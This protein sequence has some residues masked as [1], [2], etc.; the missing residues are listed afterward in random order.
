MVLL[1]HF[2]GTNGQTTFTDNSPVANTLTATAVTVATAQQKFGTGSGIFSGGG[3]SQIS[4]GASTPF[5]FGTGHFT[6]EVWGYATSAPSPGVFSLIGNFAASTGLGWEFYFNAGFLTFSWSPNGTT[7]ITTENVSYAPTLNTWVA[8]AVDYDGSNVRLY[9]N[10]A[11]LSAP[12]VNPSIFTGTQNN[13]II[14]NDEVASREWPGYL[15]EIRVTSG[16]ARYAGAY[17]PATA[18]FPNS[19]NSAG[20]SRE[21]LLDF[22]RLCFPS[23]M[24]VGALAPLALGNALKRN[25][26]ST[27][28]GLLR[29]P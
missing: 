25:K 24:L 8:Y 4:T 9:A 12:G 10:G 7:P 19:A 27:R 5:K 2:D 14:G 28:R 13:F 15:D 3:T 1:C 11:V 20:C 17:T 6:I 21:K 18:A 22:G 16:V 23:P 26:I 29:L